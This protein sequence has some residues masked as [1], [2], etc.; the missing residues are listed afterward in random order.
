[1][2]APLGKYT[3]PRR[4]GATGAAEAAGAMASRKGSANAAEIP[5]AVPSSKD[6]RESD[7]LVMNTPFSLFRLFPHLK[8]NAPHHTH[9]EGLQTVIVG[10]RL[11]DDLTDRG[12]I[13]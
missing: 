8:R 3:K 7:F 2:M 4:F 5:L 6:R 13:G 10:R 11:A 9:Y 1:M 12:H